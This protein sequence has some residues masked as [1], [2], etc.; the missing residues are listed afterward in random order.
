MNPKDNRPVENLIEGLSRHAKVLSDEERKAELRERGI[1]ADAFLGEAHSIIAQ[2][3]KEARLSWMKEAKEKASR[4]KQV[5][6]NVVSWLGKN[7][8]EIL[9]AY[10][11]IASRL[12]QEHTLA[13]R[14]KGQLSIEDMAR[15]LDDYERLHQGKSGDSNRPG[16]S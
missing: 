12:S 14:K 6:S 7:R 1:D 5:E 13:F 4:L 10:Q 8:D 3:Q 11:K 16:E 9:A 15:I 2:H